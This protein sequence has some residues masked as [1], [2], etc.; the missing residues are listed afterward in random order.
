MAGARRAIRSLRAPST[1]IAYGDLVPSQPVLPEPMTGTTVEGQ[2]LEIRGPVQGDST[3]N[4]YV[5]IRS[6]KTVIAGDIVYRGVHPWTRETNA[7]ARKAWIKTLD[8]IT[9]LKP[10]TVI[11]GHK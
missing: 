2:T 7:A 3:D 9:A 10:T 5:W 8:D 4:T 1:H 6:T 11:A